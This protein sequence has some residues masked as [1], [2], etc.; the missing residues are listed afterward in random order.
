IVNDVFHMAITITLEQP[1]IVPPQNELLIDCDRMLDEG[2][3]S[4]TTLIVD[5]TEIPVHANILAARS[6]VF[7]T[8]LTQ[9]MQEN[10]TRFIVLEDIRTATMRLV[11]KFMYTANV[12]LPAWAEATDVLI[13]ADRLQMPGLVR[14]CAHKLIQMLKLESR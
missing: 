7:K 4:D 8:M 10:K 9:P 6:P 13:V 14:H 5:S 3:F 12:E 1:P 2:L 11:L